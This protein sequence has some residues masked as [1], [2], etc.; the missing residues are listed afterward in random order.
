[1]T[2]IGNYA[3]YRRRNPKIERAFL[4]AAGE[5]RI[6][7]AVCL[8]HA[9]PSHNAKVKHCSHEFTIIIILMYIW[10]YV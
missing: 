10:V 2:A 1:M 4:H 3:L 5:A 8:S 7:K 6:H 9:L